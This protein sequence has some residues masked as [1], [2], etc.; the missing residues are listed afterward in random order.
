VTAVQIWGIWESLRNG[1]VVGSR[2]MEQALS[3]DCT[4]PSSWKRQSD[5]P[6]DVIS[7]EPVV[8]ERYVAS[9]DACL[10][11]GSSNNSRTSEAWAGTEGNADRSIAKFLIQ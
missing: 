10:V 1:S 6:A 5:P 2:D 11:D 4:S 9:P 3:R 7:R 8:S